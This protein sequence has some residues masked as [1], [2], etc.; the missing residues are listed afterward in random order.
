M[1][2][3]PIGSRLHSLTHTRALLAISSAILAISSAMLAPM[4]KATTPHLASL[5]RTRGLGIQSP[6]LE[7]GADGAYGIG[8]SEK[9]TA[10]TA[11]NGCILGFDS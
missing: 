11:R 2:P 3:P 6:S 7:K 5:A 9:L 1:V 8:L 4:A 10:K